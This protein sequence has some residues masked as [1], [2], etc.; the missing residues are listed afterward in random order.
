MV[1]I[2]KVTTSARMDSGTQ[3][4][5]CAIIEQGHTTIGMWKPIG[6]W[7][8]NGVIGRVVEWKRIA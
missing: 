1:R 2:G 5:F 3:P 6:S 7:S 8:E 4:C